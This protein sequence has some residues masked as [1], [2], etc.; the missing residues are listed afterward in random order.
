MAKILRLTALALVLLIAIFQKNA[1]A[2]V[3]CVG[4]ASQCEAL[5]SGN[6]YAAPWVIPY[7]PPYKYEP[8]DAEVGDVLWFVYSSSHN[9]EMMASESR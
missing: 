3:I 9:V 1:S 5:E 4:E 2:E 7:S 6:P 8:I